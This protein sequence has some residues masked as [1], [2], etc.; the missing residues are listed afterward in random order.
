MFVVGPWFGIFATLIALFVSG[1]ALIIAPIVGILGSYM[2]TSA[3]ICSSLWIHYA[4]L[5]RF[6][7]LYL[8]TLS[9][10]VVQKI[11]QTQLDVHPIQCQI[12]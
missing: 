4:S 5:L 10:M 12:D 3:A 6:R 2:G 8:T 11:F 1:F 7:R 9:I